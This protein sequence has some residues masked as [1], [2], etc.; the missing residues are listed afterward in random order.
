MSGKILSTVQKKTHLFTFH[1]SILAAAVVS[2]SF[3]TD[4]KVNMFD[5]LLW[6]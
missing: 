2:E 1:V 5:H 6:H 4:N 3:Y